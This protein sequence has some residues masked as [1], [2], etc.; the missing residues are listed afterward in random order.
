M[1][2]WHERQM[3]RVVAGWMFLPCSRAGASINLGSFLFGV[4]SHPSHPLILPLSHPHVKVRLP[5]EI[6]PPASLEHRFSFQDVPASTIWSSGY[7]S[8]SSIFYVTHTTQHRHKTLSHPSRICRPAARPLPAGLILAMTAAV[9]GNRVC[10]FAPFLPVDG[11]IGFVGAGARTDNCNSILADTWDWWPP[12][13]AAA[14]D[15]GGTGVAGAR[16]RGYGLR[17]RE[18]AGGR[19]EKVR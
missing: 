1:A 17:R 9:G 2:R 5:T 12:L 16:Q 15:R 7:R 10:A 3:P 13:A 14:A 4:L 6:E 8:P 19:R 18:R 11:P